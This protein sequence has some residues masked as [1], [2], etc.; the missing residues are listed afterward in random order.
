MERAEF[1]A[2]LVDKLSLGIILERAHNSVCIFLHL[3]IRISLHKYKVLYLSG[4]LREYVKEGC[5]LLAYYFRDVYTNPEVKGTHD[6]MEV[7]NATKSGNFSFYFRGNWYSS[8][9]AC[10][11]V[12]ATLY[13]VDG[14]PNSFHTGFAP[15]KKCMLIHVPEL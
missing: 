9:R 8:S 7:C 13:R 12:G 15:G 4:K 3:K 5:S 2:E 1:R 11:F 6:L 10:P 14:L